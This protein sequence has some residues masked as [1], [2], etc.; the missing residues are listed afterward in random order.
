MFQIKSFTFN[1]FDENTYILSDETHECIIIDPGCYGEDEEKALESFITEMQLKP[2]VLVNT[3]AH[4]DHVLGNNFICKKYNL[5]PVLHILELPLLEAAPV[6]GTEWGI[7]MHPSPAP[8]RFLK[9]EDVFHFGNT[10][11]KIL[12]TPGHSPGSICLFS[13]NEK[14]IISG[15]VLFQQSIGRTDL[16]GGDYDTLIRSIIEKLFVLDEKTKV[17]PGHGPETTIDLEKKLNPFVGI[18]SL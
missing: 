10:E 6:Y 13:E 17:F 9:E 11:L 5:S 7:A 12:F 16:P 18:K 15:D 1:P 14:I 8:E 2:V 4:I 3:H